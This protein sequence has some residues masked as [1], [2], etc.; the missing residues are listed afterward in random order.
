MKDVLTPEEVDALL[1]D[2][3]SG[4][5]ETGSGNR[6]NPESVQEFDLS[7][8]QWNTQ[9]KLPDLSYV[10]ELFV[11]HFQ[12][13]LQKQLTGGIEI[14]LEAS[15]SESF[16]DYLAAQQMPAS[17]NAAYTPELKDQTLVVLDAE[18]V[19]NYVTVFFGG[20]IGAAKAMERDFTVTEQNASQ[21]MIIQAFNDLAQA[22]ESVSTLSFQTPHS[23]S[24]PNF[25]TTYQPTE[26][27][28]SSRFTV[29]LADERLGCIDVVMPLACLEPLHETL[30]SSR[31]GLSK[32]QH[33]DWSAVLEQHVRNTHIELASVLTTCKMNLRDLVRLRPGDTLPIELPEHIELTAGSVPLFEGRFGTS[34]GHNAI[35]ILQRIPSRAQ[36]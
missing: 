36:T 21:K 13:S 24:D 14:S 31:Y 28:I 5:I 7:V 9:H 20:A 2:V 3:S 17:L 19:L 16:A 30:A 6:F 26:V 10:N 15:K 1:R 35:H 27:V 11:R 8:T 33:S 32:S 4:R 22:W 23:E 18:L 29:H 12:T 25:C 34:N